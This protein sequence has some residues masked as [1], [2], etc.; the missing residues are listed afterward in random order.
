MAD[1]TELQNIFEVY[2]C[3]SDAQDLIS[4]HNNPTAAY[5][6]IAHAKAHLSVIIASD[7]VMWSMAVRSMPLG[8]S[9][10]GQGEYQDHGPLVARYQGQGKACYHL[11]LQAQGDG[12]AKCFGCG[13]IFPSLFEDQ[14]QG[15]DSVE[16]DNP[17]A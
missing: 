9:L 2:S 11:T 15:D 16:G 4:E 17:D 3:L 6:R 13:E 7:P 1:V 10:Q 8:C 14:D 5:E 12:T